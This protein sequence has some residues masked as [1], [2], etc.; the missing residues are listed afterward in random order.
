MKKR[1]VKIDVIRGVAILFVMLGHSI[2]ANLL[3]GETSNL[4]LVIRAFQMPLLFLLSGFT[5]GYSYPSK[6]EEHFGF[7]AKKVKRLLIPYIMWT[8]IHYVI[9]CWIPGEYRNFSLNGLI[10]ELFESDFWFLR[11]LFMFFF[12]MWIADELC[13]VIKYIPAAFMLLLVTSIL[14][15]IDHIP[16]LEDSVNLMYWCY[17]VLGWFAYKFIGKG[18]FMFLKIVRS[19]VDTFWLMFFLLTS[20]IVCIWGLVQKP[21][22]LIMIGFP[23]SCAIFAILFLGIDENST[24]K[25]LRPVSIVGNNTLG[26]YAVHWCVLFSP[27][28][29]IG[30]YSKILGKLNLYIRVMVTFL[31]WCIICFCTIKVIKKSSVAKRI[32][33]GEA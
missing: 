17:F 13:K 9:V 16:L 27:L 12:F 25:V 21:N 29:R 8:L 4:W 24:G 18:R 31:L 3:Q 11:Y 22:L 28:W 5:A 32:L 2:Q 1:N 30:V 23:L 33:L 14:P 7:I 6:N 10:R 15:I 26:L 19:R 20:I